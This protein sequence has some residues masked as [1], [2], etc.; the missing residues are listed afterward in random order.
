VPVA[1][2]AVFRQHV[3]HF[4]PCGAVFYLCRHCDRGQRYCSG[5]CGL[6]ARR[7]QLRQA[8]R[9]HQQ[10]REGRDDHRDRQR[11]YRQRLKVR[12]T[13]QGFAA[14]SVR[15]KNE[16]MCSASSAP[17]LDWQRPAPRAASDLTE[18]VVC[19]ICGCRGH[20]INPFPEVKT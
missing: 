14:P 1:E 7:L 2:A 3:C 17:D 12:V 15:A 18:W 13:D 10:T 11:E 6:K 8:N 20:W 9:R 5:R 19:Q 16:T 4:P